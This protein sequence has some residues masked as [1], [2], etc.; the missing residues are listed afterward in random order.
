MN[1]RFQQ[2]RA[3]S[4]PRVQEAL[5]RVLASGRFVLGPEVEAFEAEFADYLGVRHA[6]GVASG[7]DA[8]TLALVAVAVGAGDRVL[9]ADFSAGYTGVAI[10]RA[11]AVPVFADVEP[12]TLCISAKSAERALRGGLIAAVVPVHLFGHAS[13]GWR[14]LRA[15]ARDRCIPVIEDACQAHGARFEGQRLGSFGEA[16]AFSFYPTKNLGALG[17]GGLV[18]TND[19]DLA[20][21]I[22]RLRAGGQKKRHHHAIPGW[23]SRLDEIQAAVLR[24]RIADLDSLNRRRRAFSRRYERGLG[25]LPLRLLEPPAEVQSARHQFVVRSPRRNS[26]RAALAA[27][28]IETLIH[29]PRA[30]HEQAAFASGPNVSGQLEEAAPEASPEASIA[31]REVISLPID[32]RLSV[33]E[34]DA[35]IASIRR[36]FGSTDWAR[37]A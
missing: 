18:A 36:F 27:C 22:R 37:S 7:T 8:L 11:G 3:N 14:Q 6:V 10:Q 17:D 19:S 30:L 23:N 32:P 20:A 5:N 25:D 21:R 35:V 16:A 33:R 9:T 31:A 12:N 13:S 15:A 2:L 29:Y 4:E 24:A 26:L 1:V 34:I 28:G